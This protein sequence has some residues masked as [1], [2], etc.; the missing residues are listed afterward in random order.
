MLGFSCFI[1]TKKK[2]RGKFLM[3]HDNV[4]NMLWKHME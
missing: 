4:F 1:I 3:L 2:N